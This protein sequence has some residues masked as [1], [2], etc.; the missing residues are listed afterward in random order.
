MIRLLAFMFGQA[1]TWWR[2]QWDIREAD[3]ARTWPRPGDVWT[4][5]GERVEVRRARV[6]VGGRFGVDLVLT[7]GQEV[8]CLWA[9]YADF[10]RSTRGMTL[11]RRAEVAP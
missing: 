7:R 2:R 3:A 6:Q 4:G 8:S 9:P 10:T 11:V 5:H 1:R